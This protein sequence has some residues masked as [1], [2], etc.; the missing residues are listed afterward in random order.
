MIGTDCPLVPRCTG[1]N[2][3]C[4]TLFR[5]SIRARS[6]CGRHL[7]RRPHGDAGVRPRSSPLMSGIDVS[8][9]LSRSS[10]WLGH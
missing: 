7:V 6:G 5:S 10:P 2:R 4:D 1:R 9:L 8:S 3:T